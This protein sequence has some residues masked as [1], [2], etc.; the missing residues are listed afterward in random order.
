MNEPPPRSLLAKDIPAYVDRLERA[1]AALRAELA[2]SAE[3][4]ARLVRE[5]YEHGHREGREYERSLHAS[6]AHA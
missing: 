1:V 6:A 2:G 4:T 5:G 3:V